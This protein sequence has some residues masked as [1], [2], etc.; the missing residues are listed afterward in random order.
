MVWYHIQALASLFDVL[1]RE[2]NTRLES[3]HLAVARRSHRLPNHQMTYGLFSFFQDYPVM[4]KEGLTC[5]L[6]A[7]LF[8]FLIVSAV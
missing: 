7:R 5:L 3:N 4:Q 1:F 8:F 6:D 2:G